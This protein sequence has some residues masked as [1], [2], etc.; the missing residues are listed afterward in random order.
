MTLHRAFWLGATL[1]GVALLIGQTG[2]APRE[3]A[4]RAGAKPPD[5]LVVYVAASVTKALQPVLDSFAARTGTVV[6]RES[7]ASLEHV[8]K[9]TEL[10]RIPDLLILADEE[11]IPQFLVPKFVDGWTTFARNRMVVAYTDRSRHATELS[12]TSWMDVLS[13][14]D[15]Q[16][17]RTDPD[18]APA[19]YRAIIM[20]HLAERFYRRPGLAATLLANA[21]KKNMRGNAAELAA[22]LSAGELDY[23]YDYRSVALANGFKLL[24]LPPEIDLGDPSRAHDYASVSIDVRGETPGTTAKMTGKPILYGAA[25]PLAAPHPAAARAFW[26]VFF[27]AATREQLR[28]AHMDMLDS[29]IT[30]HSG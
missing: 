8:R 5:T 1:S 3:S 10:G 6:Q 21:P 23:I 7:G 20:F 28:A 9:L 25:I 30:H 11:V 13:Q 17:G 24:E 4:E 27:S 19:G 12:A 16:V 18:L 29:A 26:A 14:P 15:V 22:L 2:C